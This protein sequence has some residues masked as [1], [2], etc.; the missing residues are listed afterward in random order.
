MK[1]NYTKFKWSDS[2]VKEFLHNWMQY[3]RTRAS[4]L[5]FNQ[6][7]QKFK[8]IKTEEQFIE[9]IKYLKK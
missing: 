1:V 9:K 2:L 6:Y 5:T 8:K 4:N 7:L 3:S